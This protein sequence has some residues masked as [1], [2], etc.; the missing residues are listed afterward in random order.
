MAA[1]DE[2]DLTMGEDTVMASTEINGE[3]GANATVD[4]SEIFRRLNSPQFSPRKEQLPYSLKV[5]SASKQYYIP[6]ASTHYSRE[7]SSEPESDAMDIT[8]SKSTAV[9]IRV[10]PPPRFP[11][12]PYSSSKT[13]LVYDPRM[14][15]HAEFPDFMMNPEDI[16]PEDPRRIHEIFE[17]IHQAGLVQGPDDPDEEASE[18]QCWRIEARS[19]TTAEICLIHT[20]E[21]YIFIESLQGTFTD[22]GS[23]K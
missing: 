17:E 7:S 21:H 20:A 19:A 8:P 1:I 10:P 22:V 3:Q 14:R 18:E 13:G 5:P 4:P 23:F 15:F 16:H 12:L 9:E 2:S 6:N 11:P